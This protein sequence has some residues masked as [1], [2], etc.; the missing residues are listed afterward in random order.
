MPD[1]ARIDCLLPDKAVE[2]DFAAKWAECI[3]QALY[4]AQMTNRTPACLLIIENPQRDYK[5]LMRLQN[6][7]KNISDFK[8][9]TITPDD[10]KKILVENIISFTNVI[11]VQ[12]VNL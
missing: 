8:I 4:Y 7:V 1:K 12:F 6:A 11:F 5:Y 9:F 3:G 2:V 10:L